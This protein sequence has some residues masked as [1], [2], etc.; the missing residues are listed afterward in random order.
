MMN[1]YLALKLI[2]II[3]ATVLFGTGLGSAY[4]MWRTH[5][6]GDVRAIAEVSRN[7]VLA[8]WLFTTPAVVLQ[9]LTGVTMAV[10]AGMSLSESWL[11]G[12]IVLYAIAGACWLP[13]VWLQIQIR[14]MAVT[15]VSTGTALPERYHR[16]MKA[17]FVLGWPAFIAVAL[18]FYLMVY[19][20]LL[21]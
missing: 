21:W 5:R 10:L 1:Q 2:H 19:K 14:N 15:A 6:G 17:W 20:P 12:A 4:Y 11:L 16:F 9:P 3:S 13:V 7:V 8:D 18:T